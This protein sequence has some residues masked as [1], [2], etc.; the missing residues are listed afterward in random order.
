MNQI[1]DSYADPVPAPAPNRTGWRRDGPRFALVAWVIATVALAATAAG[2]A[3][4][5]SVVAAVRAALGGE[6]SRDRLGE[7]AQEA[8]RSDAF[9]WITVIATQ[10]A[11]LACAWL[12]CRI[13]RR[14][15][16]ERL[17]LRATGLGPVQGA[18]VLVATVVPFA[19]GLAAAWLVESAIGSSSDDA[20]GLQR[21]W[22]EG[23][24]GGSVAWVLL[25]A[26]LPGFVEEVFYRGFL[27]RG[28][29][30][31]WGAAASILT[32][33]VLFA[34]SHGELA[35][36]AA[37]FPLGVWLG[38]VAWR[39][40]SVLMTFAIHASVNGL[41]TAGMMIL[42]REPAS[43]QALNEIAIALLAVSVIAFPW[44]IAIL[45]RQP[46]AATSVVTRRPMWLLQRVAGVGIVAGA[47]LF[48]LVPP[49]AL[50]MS[51]EQAATQPVPT[52]GELEASAVEDATC[53]AAGDDGAVE[54][55][56]MPGVG[57]RVAL[58]KNRVGID[59]VIVTLDAAGETVWLA[60]AGERSGKGGKRRPVGIVEQLASGDPTV[61]RMT[62][63]Q[64]PPPVTVRLTLEED[65]AMKIA[66]FAQAEAEGWAMRGRK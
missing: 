50:P 17:G 41:W 49:G 13:L 3:I 21:M 6:S 12:A 53:A 28:L 18:V 8:L 39:T 63:T 2:A 40:G 25:I 45:R 4:V 10:V 51:P 36:A 57:T 26:L 5:V 52:L 54:F 64:G 58:P 55:F 19:L 47:F 60:Y 14:P 48:L 9:A 11:L 30:L 37:I 46:A 29:L 15:V 1:P 38:V 59:E 33:S 31:R 34:V 66:A 61:L 62:L 20:L 43:E 32:S 7:I 44:A 42:H 65:E 35:W 24:R 23:S 27:Q 16:H 56:L 22:S